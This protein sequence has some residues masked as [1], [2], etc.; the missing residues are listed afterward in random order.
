MHTTDLTLTVVRTQSDSLIRAEITAQNERVNLERACVDAITKLGKSVDDV[1]EA[2]G[3]TPADIH[4]ILYRDTM[5]LEDELAQ[6]V[7][8]A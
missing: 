4:R 8:A 6:L 1:S 5:V 3:L 7:G 2:S